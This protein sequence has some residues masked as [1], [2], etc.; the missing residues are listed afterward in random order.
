MLSAIRS[1]LRLYRRLAELC[2][3]VHRLYPSY[4]FLSIALRLVNTVSPILTLWIAK[5]IIDAV[6]RPSHRGPNDGRDIVVLA[7]L[8]GAVVVGGHVLSTFSV[9]M[10]TRVEHSVNSSLSLRLLEHTAQLDLAT[11]ENSEFQ[12]RLTRA[13]EQIANAMDTLTQLLGLA[14]QCLRAGIALSILLLKSPWLVLQCAAIVPILYLEMTNSSREY[15]TYKNLTRERR[16]AKY[17][18]E[19]CSS[20]S[21][22][23]ES[24]AFNSYALVKEWLCATM[25]RIGAEEERDRARL[26]K[27]TAIFELFA[28][29]SFY[30]AY[31]FLAWRAYTGIITPGDLIFM[32]GLMQTSRNQLQN[33][34]QGSAH[35]FTRVVRLNEIFEI[36]EYRPTPRRTGS[37][38]PM[39]QKI[40]Q[41]VEFRSVG[42]RYPG[43]SSET[44]SDISFCIRPGE[45]VALFGVNGS[46]KSTITKLLNRLYDPTEGTVFLEGCDLREYEL[47]ELRR[48][49][50]LVFQDFARYNRSAYTNVAIG[51]PDRFDDRSAVIQSVRR[52]GAGGLIN[53]FKERYDQMLGLSFEG[54]ID[55]SG[56]QWQR[57]AI[58][59]GCMA[60]AL[61]Y[62]FDEP[63][64]SIDAAAEYDLM[65]RLTDI[66]RGRMSLIV[67]HRFSTLRRADRIVVLDE[68]RI[69][70]QGTHGQLLASGGH[71]ATMFRLQASLFETEANFARAAIR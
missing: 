38:R 20:P 30:A 24:R 41:G 2:R 13:Q 1:R 22:A 29:G 7:L 18:H 14:E 49:V 12:D 17:L 60:D 10:D 39:P 50:S 15:A 46:G 6:S 25:R 53:S 5:K 35:N 56:G 61:I 55:L 48:N 19:L 32:V 44:L 57:L 21:Y 59:R 64:S 31:A 58:A 37:T 23:K 4:S 62:V 43:S 16:E 47:G 40:Y 3:E 66:I 52:A 28:S 11:I 65:N 26:V 36:F 8:E 27:E 63:T 71:Y 54:G 9:F 68:G 70:Q 69:V 45:C 42:F 34:L 67:S 51:A 33:I